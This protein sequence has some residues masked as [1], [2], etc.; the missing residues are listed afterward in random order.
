MRSRR[1]ITS[2]LS[3]GSAAGER[4]NCGSRSGRKPWKRAVSRLRGPRRG[5][6]RREIVVV[7]EPP[8]TYPSGQLRHVTACRGGNWGGHARAP[9]PRAWPPYLS[10]RAGAELALGA[11]RAVEREGR[12]AVEIGVVGAVGA[13]AAPAQAA[14]LL[15]LDAHDDLGA[16]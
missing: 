2:P 7:F 4:A 8:L 3:A 13:P 6:R 15:A 10:V 16:L 14:S 12:R 1:G 5:R 11:G 9:S